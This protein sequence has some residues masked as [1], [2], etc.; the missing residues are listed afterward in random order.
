MGR[1]TT[2]EMEI[3]RFAALSATI[4][5][6]LGKNSDQ[7]NPSMVQRRIQEA[8]HEKLEA[9][10]LS[11]FEPD[12]EDW[13]DTYRGLY[14]SCGQ[15]FNEKL[16]E[17]I[18]RYFRPGWW[19]VLVQPEIGRDILWAC[20][21]VIGLGIE[22]SI[23]EDVH[24]AITSRRVARVTWVRAERNVKT[25]GPDDSTRCVSLLEWL[26]LAFALNSLTQEHLD[27]AS[28]NG[29]LMKANGGVIRAYYNRY[30]R[31]PLRIDTWDPKVCKAMPRE[32][33]DRPV[34]P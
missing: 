34:S 24:R 14:E 10:L 4:T 2:E 33:F 16:G 26:P 9:K 19:P 3:P 23:K 5:Q 15:I 29:T 18:K 21:G 8:R 1:I 17:D 7:L 32:R 31:K 20:N 13:T 11:I 6:V 25:P 22:P 12:A 27:D 30:L 28:V